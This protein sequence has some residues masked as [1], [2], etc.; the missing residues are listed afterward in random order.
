MYQHMKNKHSLDPSAQASF[1]QAAVSQK[2]GRPRKDF[3]FTNIDPT[4]DIYLSSEGRQGGP[5]DPLTHF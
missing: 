4:S 5:L 3:N 1:M 2:R